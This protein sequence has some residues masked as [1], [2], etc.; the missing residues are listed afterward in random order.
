MYTSR[1]NC[2]LST[3]RR[4]QIYIDEDL[5]E[6]LAT[7]ALRQGTSKAALIRLFVAERLGSSTLARD[8]LDELVGEYDEEPRLIDNLVYGR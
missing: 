5:D 7:Q 1:F 4:L 8:P 6:A 3:M 2:I